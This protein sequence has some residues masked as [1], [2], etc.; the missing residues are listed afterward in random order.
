[1]SLKSTN[2]SMQSSKL[3]FIYSTN[4]FHNPQNHQGIQLHVLNQNGDH[5][6]NFWKSTQANLNFK[7]QVN[8]C[9]ALQKAQ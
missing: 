4:W 9:G 1:M 5:L 8:I 3:F 2:S 7:L 6:T